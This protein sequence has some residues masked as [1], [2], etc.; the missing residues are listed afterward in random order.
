MVDEI[1]SEVKRPDLTSE[2]PRYVNQ[3]IRECHF[4]TDRQAAI[5]FK[6]N[7]NEALVTATVESGQIWEMPNPTTFQKIVGVKYPLQFDSF[8]N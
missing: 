4:S 8:D 2:I 7:F 5:F 1:I 3:T 6:D